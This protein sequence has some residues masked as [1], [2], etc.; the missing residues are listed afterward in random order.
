MEAI[1]D[2]GIHACFKTQYRHN[3]AA[4]N[5]YLSLLIYLSSL[6]DGSCGL[7]GKCENRW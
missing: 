6:T 5:D 1:Q 4:S 3:R 2:Q 7:R